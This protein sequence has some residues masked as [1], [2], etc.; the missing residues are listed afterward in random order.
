MA[1]V[2]R[3]LIEDGISRLDSPLSID[4]V[5]RINRGVDALF[6]MR[7]GKPRSYVGCDEL[8][9]QGLLVPML[10]SLRDTVLSILPDPTLYHCHLYET[11]GGSDRA[12]I[13]GETLA[14]WHRDPDSEYHKDRATHV[15]IFIHLSDVGLGDG[16]F[17]FCP[18]D[19]EKWLTSSTPV[20]SV[21][22]PINTS[23][24][25]NRAFMHRASPNSGTKRRRM[26]KLSIQPLGSYNQRRDNPMFARAR[27]IVPGGDNY[28]DMMLGRDPERARTLATTV[29]VS[30]EAMAHTGTLSVS[31]IVIMETIAKR[32]LAAARKLLRRGASGQ[33]ESVSD[34]E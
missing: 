5:T 9:E 10:E 30:G 29:P 11:A 14:G 8:A 21:V 32:K 23:F 19:P 20:I 6:A 33:T 27:E 26:L 25:W 18:G 28:L 17:E 16:A 7:A 3:L 15:S 24:A 2:R 4:L 31:N 22:G 13:Y 1:D 12:H 34:Y